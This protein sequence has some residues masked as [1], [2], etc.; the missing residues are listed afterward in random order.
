MGP[1]PVRDCI[2]DR[3]VYAAA[4]SVSGVGSG[5]S[6]FIQNTGRIA[7]NSPSSKWH[8]ILWPSPKSR[9]G[10]GNGEGGSPSNTISRLSAR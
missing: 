1:W 7:F 5:F 8:A 9:S 4:F 3:R 10:G 6:P 2:P